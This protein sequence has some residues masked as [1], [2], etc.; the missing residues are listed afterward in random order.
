MRRRLT[1][2]L[3]AALLACQ[4]E[5]P[6]SRAVAGPYAGTYV[7]RSATGVVAIT[8]RPDGRV[9]NVTSTAGG[10]ATMHDGTYTAV[11][12]TLYIHMALD[13]AAASD[14]ATRAVVRGRGGDTLDVLGDVGGMDRV[15][16]RER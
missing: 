2:C 1:L 10:A 11:G 16:V 8:L 6:R 5:S 4:G 15:F 7:Q 9:Q 12:D 13:G 3:V 14:Y